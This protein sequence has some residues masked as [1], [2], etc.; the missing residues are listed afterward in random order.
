MSTFHV[1]G[2]DVLNPALSP[3]QQ[4]LLHKSLIM[5]YEAIQR[6]MILAQQQNNYAIMRTPLI[7]AIEL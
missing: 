2:M 3:Q 1:P 5:I 7:R 4:V 6:L